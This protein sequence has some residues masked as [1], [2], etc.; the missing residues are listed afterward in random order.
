MRFI[1][2]IKV[3]LMTIVQRPGGKK[4]EYTAGSFMCY[5]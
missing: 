2:H 1:R 3:K 4:W 5:R